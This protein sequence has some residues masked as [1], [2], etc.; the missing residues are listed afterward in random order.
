H[1]VEGS[2]TRPEELDRLPGQVDLPQ[3]LHRAELGPPHTAVPQTRRMRGRCNNR[4]PGGRASAEKSKVGGSEASEVRQNGGEV[5]WRHPEPA[6]ERRR[7]LVRG[8]GGKPPALG[9]E[10]VG[11]PERERGKRAVG[12]SA[13]HRSPEHEVVVAPGVV[14]AT[15]GGRR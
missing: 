1:L 14:R 3:E 15:T 12:L 11:P 8:G 2:V 13:L 4:K 10:V 9:G 5:P 6:S 7:V